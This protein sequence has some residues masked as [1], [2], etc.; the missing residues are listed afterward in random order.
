[1]TLNVVWILL[2]AKPTVD[3]CCKTLHTSH[4]LFGLTVNLILD[5]RFSKPRLFNVEPI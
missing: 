2:K 3:T 4:V 1:M 5:E